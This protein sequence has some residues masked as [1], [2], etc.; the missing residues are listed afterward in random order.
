MAKAQLSVTIQDSLGVKATQNINLTLDGTQTI[1]DVG[2]E[3]NTYLPLLNALIDGIIIEARLIWIA[4]LPGGLRTTPVDKSV[5]QRGLLQSW[6]QAVDV[7]S[8]P[9]TLVP[10]I[11]LGAISATTGKFDQTNAA[12]LAWRSH[13]LGLTGPAITFTSKALYNITGAYSILETFRKHRKRTAE[14]SYEK[15]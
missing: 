7:N 3:I 14:L 13:L 6:T 10:C 11:T 12:Y 8:H 4:D 15:E 5:V 9:S 1:D 2:S